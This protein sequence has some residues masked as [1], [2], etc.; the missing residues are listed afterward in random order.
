MAEAVASPPSTPLAHPNG[1]R[2][3]AEASSAVGQVCRRMS[4]QR[5]VSRSGCRAHFVGRAYQSRMRAGRARLVVY[6]EK[7]PENEM[8]VGVFDV[9]VYP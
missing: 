8:R 7:T 3:R 2:T 6:L 4:V 5:P 1:A 9:F